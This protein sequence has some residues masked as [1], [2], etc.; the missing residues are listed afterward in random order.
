MKAIKVIC[1]L[2]LSFS[3]SNAIAQQWIRIEGLVY[4]KKTNEPLSY[5]SVYNKSS[6]K[7]TLTNLDGFFTID[8]SSIKDT[9][10]INFIGYKKLARVELK[11]NQTSYEIYLEENTQLLG[12][13]IIKPKDNSYLYDLITDCKKN[14]KNQKTEA[15]AY[16]ELK[17]YREDEQVEL[18]EAFYNVQL[19]GYE[20]K[21]LDMKAGRLALQPYNERLFGSIESSRAIT[22]LSFF[23]ANNFFPISPIE[24]SPKELKK[25]F[26]LRLEKKYLN[27]SSDSIYVLN[28]EPKD[29]PKSFFQGTLWLDKTNKHFIKITLE[30][31]QTSRHPFLP[32]FP[33]DTISSVTFDI[34]KTFESNHGNTFFNHIDF[35]YTINYK[36][37]VGEVY[38]EFYTVVSKAVLHV[39]DFDRKFFAPT[40]DKNRQNLSDYRRINA[41]PYN[42]F[43]WEKNNEFRLNGSA[44]ANEAFFT[45]ENTETSK[46]I[47]SSNKVQGR[48]LFEHPYVAW[49]KDRRISI[50]EF[51]GD[52]IQNARYVKTKLEQY[53]LD[54]ELF[55]DVNTY[56]DSTQILTT[57]IFDPYDTYYNLPM[58]KKTDCFINLYFDL[59]EIER[60]KLHEQITAKPFSEKEIGNLYLI[61][62]DN[63]SKQQYNYIKLLDRGTNEKEMRRLNA[64]VLE[65]IG[66]DN[67]ALFNPFEDSK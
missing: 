10:Q 45:N 59:C 55:L 24:L 33:P 60:R 31:A 4:D 8:I 61:F 12:E 17:S 9:I 1:L 35:I 51:K 34:T 62:S 11:N 66:I 3:F 36:S 14:A 52:T 46:N 23:K 65:Q 32:L 29:D 47:F 21:E 42:D 40:F 64:F 67:I 18:V 13:V 28:F 30:C 20:L 56:S 49:S 54:V 43:F 38:Q 44:V 2:C 6:Q 37:R 53:N 16:Y 50:R 57:A 19:Q 39:Y 5:A 27:E 15:K 63:Y 58:D 25:K 41:M 48:K 22:E 26:Y 7:G